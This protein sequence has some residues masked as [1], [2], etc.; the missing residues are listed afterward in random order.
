[1]S[2]RPLIVFLKDTVA[3]DVDYGA[4][5]KKSVTREISKFIIFILEV[6]F[7]LSAVAI[8]CIFGFPI[9][10]I[11]LGVTFLRL[12]LLIIFYFIQIK[13]SS[14][15]SKKLL[16]ARNILT[17]L[18]YATMAVSDYFF[19]ALVPAITFSSLSLIVMFVENC[20]Y[21]GEVI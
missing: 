10:F 20:F 6:T 17:I 12:T 7:D 4:E 8:Y 9:Y 11:A 18:F 19:M 21:D 1:M 5:I 14:S 16:L 3:N 2:K 13:N 15:K